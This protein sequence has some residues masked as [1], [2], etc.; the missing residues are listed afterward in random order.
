M[1]K[2]YG[3]I[4]N[5]VRHGKV[6]GV[7][8]GALLLS[9]VVLASCSSPPPPPPPPNHVPR[10]IS[11]TADSFEVPVMRSTRISCVAVDADG[12]ALSYSWSASG[13][14]IEGDGSGVVWVA[15]EVPGE[16]S[17]R[18]TVSDGS[19]GEASRSLTLK[20][21]ERP[22]NPP[23]IVALTVDGLPPKEVNSSR[24]YATHTI[25]CVAEDPDG[26][27][28]QYSWVKTGGKLTGE[29]AEVGWTAPGLTDE[30]VVTVVVSDGRGGTATDSV[31]FSVSCCGK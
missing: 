1:R 12:D 29:G 4:G 10:I 20:A 28:L 19:G 5:G 15:P 30:Y 24:A 17:V 22:N 7:L 27:N 13:G 25:R 6:V 3:E 23:K 2:S 14:T 11:L 31:R 9:A 18:V 16:Y 21:F 26:D 8:A